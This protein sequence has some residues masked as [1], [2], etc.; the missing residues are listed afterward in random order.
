MPFNLWGHTLPEMEK[1]VLDQNFP[2][3]R[4]KQIQDYLYKR[5][6]FDID[7]MKQL[8]ETMR[9]SMK[10]ETIL[11]K[12]VIMSSIQSNDGNTTKILLKLAD[13]S[14]IETV[15][16][17]HN[18]G[19][20]ICVST[21][22]GCSMGCIFCAS[23]RN[24]LERNLTAGEIL[25]QVYAFKEIMDIPVHS[26]VL[27]GSGEPLTNYEE[28]LRFIHL[29]ND[30]GLLNISF[31]NITLSTCGIVPQIYRLADEKLPITLAISLHAPNDRIRNEI[32]PV[33]RH[34]KIEDV[35]KAA[36]YYFKTTGRR[37]T[38]EYIL[39][40]NINASIENA[41][42]LC[43][44][45][46]KMNCHFNLIP[47]N[48]TEHIQLFPPT[49]NEIRDFQSLLE[50]HGKSTTVRKQMGDEIQ[51]ACGQLKRRYMANK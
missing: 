15:C 25:A 1:W 39:I 27:M 11:E 33:S 29:C 42:E 5:H 30:P 43:R 21:Q 7:A 49:P 8:P 12:P 45:V 46:G 36:G 48:G 17:H 24:G 44:L 19:N 16:M 23:T 50:K 4:A 37:V 18:Y 13:G 9:A 40:R 38:F 20:S 41:E 2:R 51:A 22:V 34:F 14:L 10:S 32:L 31:R 35:I 26:I 28:V 47:I 6:I 3:F